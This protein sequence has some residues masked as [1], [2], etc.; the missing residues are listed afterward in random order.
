MKKLSFV[1]ALMLTLWFF[2]SAQS[3]SS[4]SSEHMRYLNFF[5]SQGLLPENI[6]E[7]SLF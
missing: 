6:H 4:L 7:G 5:K 1:F 3:S 2:S